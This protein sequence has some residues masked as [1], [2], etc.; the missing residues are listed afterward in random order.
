MLRAVRALDESQ[1]VAVG[2]VVAPA[3]RCAEV[4]DLLEA[5]ALTPRWTTVPGGE[6][7]AESVARGLRT[8]PADVDIVLVHDA[9]RAFVPAA[10]VRRVVDAIAAG[11]DAV[12][13]VV[14][15][16]DTVKQV[17]AS[18]VVVDTVDRSRL[19]QV[20]TPQGFRRP[21]LD[22]A[23]AAQA[24]R[25]NDLSGASGSERAVTDDAGV[26]EALGVPVVVVEGDPLA[27]KVTGPLDLLLAEA[28]VGPYRGGGS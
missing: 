18:G 27:F 12:V 22:A 4:Q 6:T 13:P 23:Y 3:E 20:Q 16:A 14:P 25:G 24:A 2:V 10:A 19:R 7:R 21:V 28:L 5:A 8:L 15:V 9:A 26:V 17:D 11:A 1:L